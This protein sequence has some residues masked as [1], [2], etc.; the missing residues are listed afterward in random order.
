MNHIQTL[1]TNNP[2]FETNRAN[3]PACCDEPWWD[4]AGA[5]KA[6]E[7]HSVKRLKKLPNG[8]DL[9]NVLADEFVASMM[10]VMDLI[11]SEDKSIENSMDI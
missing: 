6:G 11:W 4:S 5:I 1:W 10:D 2:V 9:S 3:I 7:I 8:L